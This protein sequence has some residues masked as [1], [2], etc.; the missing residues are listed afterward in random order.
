MESALLKLLQKPT[1]QGDIPLGAL[2]DRAYS[3]NDSTENSFEKTLSSSQKQEEYDN[4]NSSDIGATVISSP[5]HTSKEDPS[6]YPLNI[7]GQAIAAPENNTER[8]NT[9]VTG[10]H[11]L[12]LAQDISNSVAAADTQEIYN[13]IQTISDSN[14]PATDFF[15]AAPDTEGTLLLP[16]ELPLKE[17]NK[18]TIVET[19]TNT[20]TS[21]AEIPD[22]QSIVNNKEVIAAVGG[23]ENVVKAVAGEIIN[24]AQH[25]AQL[26][27][28][29]DDL[30][31]TSK[32]DKMLDSQ[33]KANQQ[34]AIALDTSNGADNN[35]L[36]PLLTTLQQRLTK[37]QNTLAKNN[38]TNLN[39]GNITA[40]ENNALSQQLSQT[41]INDGE[42]FS[43]KTAKSL[44]T[45]LSSNNQHSLNGSL[46]SSQI[47]NDESF[48]ENNVN[49]E[50]L[51]MTIEQLSK[52]NN[53]HRLVNQKDVIA[54]IKFG[55]DQIAQ[56]GTKQVSVQLYPKELGH[57][58]IHMETSKDGQTHVKI[59]AERTETMN[60]L[61]K[62][63]ES[64]RQIL[65]DSL[66]ADNSQ[67][68]FSFHEKSH[69]DWQHFAN[70]FDNDG[71][72]QNA[73]EETEKET[74]TNY[75]GGYTVTHDGID[76]RV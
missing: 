76:I 70:Q 26:P 68:S 66:K 53:A 30:L 37:T 44:D 62:E 31:L 35:D 10:S 60:L 11:L 54:Q 13:N 15:L 75:Y 20:D 40:N 1:A 33:K 48:V 61:Q 25:A 55:V 41:E 49:F 23:Q 7:F 16:P 19:T 73:T 14:N 65:Q 67:L 45:T 2:R 28:L 43:Q 22:L 36:D 69:D 64:L 42:T 59:I 39:D 5:Y 50:K 47:L 38:T 63:S 71:L 51:N 74:T 52:D 21:K 18:E 32:I 34:Q 6:R 29:S 4:I 72:G 3:S 24:V 17:N 56:S 46:T 12:T 8:T 27:E 58:D 57:V 9:Q